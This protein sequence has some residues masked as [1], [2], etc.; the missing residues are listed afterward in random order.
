M[1]DSATL[2]FRFVLSCYIKNHVKHYP[3]KQ[4]ADDAFFSLND[5]KVIQGLDELIKYYQRNGDESLGLSLS[6]FSFAKGTLPPFEF[7]KQGKV[8]PLHHAALDN[9]FEN[10]KQIVESKSQS[11]NAKDRKG[12]TPLHIICM[13]SEC[14]IELVKFLIDNGASFTA[15]DWSGRSPFLYACEHNRRSIVKLMVEMNKETIQ[16]R[17]SETYDVPMHVAARFGHIWLVGFLLSKNAALRPRN[18]NGKL[19]IDLA[20]DGRFDRIVCFLHSYATSVKTSS[21]LWNHGSLIRPE[22]QHRLKLKRQELSVRLSDELLSG[23][24]LVRYSDK[25][26][27]HVITM[28]ESDDIMNYEILKTVS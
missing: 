26:K 14:D 24:F 5:E 12:Q 13:N 25:A 23:L 10:I 28:L 17:N 9:D 15:R 19:P 18:K 6:S 2:K 3:I 27:K 20:A 11:I 16:M 1:R 7:C 21:N 4:H 8:T 22:A